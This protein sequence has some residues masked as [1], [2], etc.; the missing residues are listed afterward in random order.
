MPRRLD[1]R[2]GPFVATGVRIM[3]M[4]ESAGAS[5]GNGTWPL[6]S[7]ADLASGHMTALITDVAWQRPDLV[8]L[9]LSK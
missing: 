5:S 9:V 2:V 1:N 3:L 4:L 7:S 6:G 8:E